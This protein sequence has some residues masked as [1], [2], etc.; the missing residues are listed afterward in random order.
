[1]TA[2]DGTS[3]YMTGA[4]T[5]AATSSNTFTSVTFNIP[6]KTIS[7]PNN[8]VNLKLAPKNPIG[9]NTYLRII[10]QS[11]MSMS[12]IYGGNNLVTIPNQVAG[13][14]AGQILLGNLT[15]NS[16]TSQPT[17]LSLTNFFLTNPPYA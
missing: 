1:M 11:D 2:S 6:N 17:L 3:V 10:T 16:S 13:Q 4:T 9:S 5:F 7:T 8:N 15:K 14:P 12:Y